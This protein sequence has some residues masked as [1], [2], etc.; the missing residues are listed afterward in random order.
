MNY[1]SL[2]I[3]LAKCEHSDDLI[4]V[5]KNKGLWDNVGKYWRQIGG[6]ENANTHSTVGNQGSTPSS[7]IVEKL[8]NCGD[9]ALMCMCKESNLEGSS[10]PNSVNDARIK[11][12]G[13]PEGKWS[14][15]Q[16]ELKRSIAS[17]FCNL[18]VTGKKGDKPTI[19]IIDNAEGQD[20]KDFETTFLSLTRGN[21]A[22]IPFVQGRFG[23]GSQGAL[24]F[25]DNGLQLIISKKNPIFAKDDNEWGFT[26]TR[27]VL[28][29]EA[30]KNS[31]WMY[32][33]I[34][35]QIP[36]FKAENLKLY[37]G[38]YPNPYGGDFKYGSF[39]KMF[40]MDLDK[41]L[42]GNAEWELFY[43]LNM[44]LVNPVVP[45]N[46]FERR[47]GWKGVGAKGKICSGLDYRLENQD[48]TK[49]VIGFGPNSIPIMY[50]GNK[51]MGTL[52]GFNERLPRKPDGTLGDKV[53]MDRW[54]N[55]VIFNS[56][57][58][59]SGVIPYSFFHQAGLKYDI[60]AKNLLLIIDC[61]HLS[62]QMNE[63]IFKPD[64]ER[65]ND[66]KEVNEIKEL[67]REELKE[68]PGLK[69]F[70]S[71]V[72]N[73]K[74]NER[75]T[76]QKE[77]NKL[78]QKMLTKHPKFINYLGFGEDFKNPFDPRGPQV[79]D[80][81]EPKFYPTFF[82]FKK[83]Y[84]V[85]SPR[86]LEKGRISRIDIITDAPNDYL[87]RGKD[88]G[89]FK[90]TLNGEDV[91][92]TSGISLSGNDGRWHLKIPTFE[93]DINM[94]FELNISDS[95]GIN[96]EGFNLEL[97]GKNIDKVET[98]ITP[99]RPR[100]PRVETN[101]KVPEIVE[102]H[103]DKFADEGFD[104]EDLLKVMPDGEGGK[105]FL[106]N[107]DNKYFLQYSKENPAE[108]E[109]IKTQYKLALTIFC[110]AISERYEKKSNQEIDLA[111]YSRDSAKA[112]SPVFMFILREVYKL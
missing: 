1:K 88:P 32:L 91:T 43:K 70:L 52:Y 6:D 55:G 11:L 48:G 109:L 97:W 46:I 85:T 47:E 35:N 28:P 63:F 51:L 17:K 96:F 78:F 64:R 112:I 36:S 29:T 20:P 53:R 8:V 74:Y 101:K 30:Y 45:I 79:M 16:E 40:N 58:Q 50:D 80:E 59:T 75:A 95:S 21:K 111:K 81:F 33:K 54:G 98:P 22:A 69:K 84:R 23:M 102:I 94:H 104:D 86:E 60:I 19:S 106:A 93:V 68:H 65:L 89:D 14:L 27:R 7:A 3:E 71:E 10:F 24:I 103:K 67:I 38:E 107:M 49:G 12:F 61:S 9:S 25:L 34:D 5:L 72:K 26:V 57:G 2:C 4:E 82:E 99:V 90:L 110:M 37:P 15:A 62:T 87:S 42:R 108:A 44:S 73:K 100:P 66:C 31:R 56:N 13:V 39:I 76:D 18:V 105:L 92:R 41:R 83:H 77:I